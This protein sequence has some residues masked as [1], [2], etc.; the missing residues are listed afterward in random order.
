MC[1]KLRH[2]FFYGREKLIPEMFQ[3]VLDVLKSQSLNC[4]T[5][6]YYLERH[7]EVDAHEHGPKAMRLL[8]ELL[9]TDKKRN[10]HSLARVLQGTWV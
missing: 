9:D 8:N 10:P 5:L 1:M 2:L 7:I 4:P 3:S 6:I